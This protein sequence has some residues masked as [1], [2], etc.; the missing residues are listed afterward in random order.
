MSIQSALKVLK[1]SF[2]PGSERDF[3]VD[4]IT[5]RMSQAS[6]LDVGVGDGQS[7]DKL[8]QA[9]RKNGCRIA[10]I[11]AVDP[12]LD[13]ARNALRD[14]TNVTL[15]K[16]EIEN[17]SFDRKFDVIN[18]R[19]SAHYFRPIVETI[20]RLATAREQGGVLLLTHWSAE[21]GL[22][23][24]HKFLLQRLRR[25]G[26]A[27]SP[28]VEDIMAEGRLSDDGFLHAKLQLFYDWIDLDMWRDDFVQRLAAFDIASRSDELNGGVTE[29]DKDSFVREFLQLRGS[30]MQRVNGVVIVG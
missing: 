28:S 30:R 24:L 18:V 26:A 7:T 13:V 5:Q 25:A 22:Y 3:I 17:A 2:G 19:Q 23:D 21:C 8:V 14:V 4:A 29:S 1:K 16:V 10:D 20:I 11:V 9:V 15:L 27:I 12:E 6:W